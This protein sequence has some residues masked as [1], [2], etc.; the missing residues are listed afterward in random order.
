MCSRPTS[1][2]VT[3]R[4]QKR[5]DPLKLE[6][7]MPV[8][9][10]VVVHLGLRPACASLKIRLFVN[11]WMEGREG[12]CEWS[13]ILRVAAPLETNATCNSAWLWSTMRCLPNSKL[14][15]QLACPWS[16]LRELPVTVKHV[17]LFARAPRLAWDNP[18][19]FI[20]GIR[21][22]KV[23]NDRTRKLWNKWKTGVGSP[24]RD[25]VPGAVALVQL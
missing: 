13:S 19:C 5:S 15:R 17:W 11:S 25:T 10:R 22:N 14:H 21:C 7:H 9:Y 2:P 23:P 8:G 20:Q 12:L 4:G 1:M 24:C 18:E 6:L 3:H 16:A